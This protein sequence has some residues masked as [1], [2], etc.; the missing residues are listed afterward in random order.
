MTNNFALWINLF[1]N[2]RKITFYNTRSKKPGRRDQAQF[3]GIET[4]RSS[5]SSRV[6]CKRDGKDEM[7][8]P[9][10]NCL[11][12]EIYLQNY[13]TANSDDQPPPG[14]DSK[15]YGNMIIAMNSSSLMFWSVLMLGLGFSPITAVQD[16]NTETIVASELQRL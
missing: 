14:C 3:F 11:K 10:K 12:F 2:I 6:Y 13:S 16:V 15:E 8:L 9:Q 4:R 5:Q 1:C 7:L